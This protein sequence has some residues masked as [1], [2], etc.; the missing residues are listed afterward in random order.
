VNQETIAEPGIN[1]KISELHAAMGRC[2]LP[3]VPELIR[4]RKRISAQ[5][6]AAFDTMAPRL[7]RPRPRAGTEAN[8]A[9]YPIL[10]ETE[11]LLQRVRRA[12][13]S[14]GVEPRRYF[15]P[16]LSTLPFGR[17]VS[18]A[19]SRS[20]AGRVLCLPLWAGLPET[21]VARIAEIVA[22]VVRTAGAGEP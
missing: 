18:D 17:T 4:E 8:H 13:Q 3:R 11:A 7:T 16:S 6:D 9:Y 10:L 20:A 19:V 1:A 15:H 12:L 2:L 22:S 21:D 14:A 5:Y